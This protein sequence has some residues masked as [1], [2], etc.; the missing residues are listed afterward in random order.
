V[1][2]ASCC[3]PSAGAES[4]NGEVLGPKW[5]GIGDWRKLRV[6]ELC[7]LYRSPNITEAIECRKVGFAGHVACEHFREEADSET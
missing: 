6:G 4:G 5:G 2:A 3:G 1:R 7:G